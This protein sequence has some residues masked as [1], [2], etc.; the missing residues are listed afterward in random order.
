MYIFVLSYNSHFDVVP[1]N[2][3]LSRFSTHLHINSH[4]RIYCTQSSSK[5]IAMISLTQQRAPRVI[6]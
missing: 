3:N 4:S 6:R 5:L 1:V 2:D